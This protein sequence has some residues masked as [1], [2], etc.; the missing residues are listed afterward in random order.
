MMYNPN[1]GFFIDLGGP[2]NVDEIS[3][4]V[5]NFSTHFSIVSAYLSMIF[6]FWKV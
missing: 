2:G 5:V 3:G 4:G 6:L 1:V